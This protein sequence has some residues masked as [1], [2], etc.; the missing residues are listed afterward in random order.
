MQFFK[1]KTVLFDLDGT[2]ADN[3][4]AITKGVAYALGKLNIPA[5]TC[6][7]VKSVVGGSI[8]VTMERLIGKEL[9]T[10]AAKIYASKA[11]EYATFGL[12]AMPCARELLETLRAKKI[13][14]AC[15]TNKESQVAKKVLQYLKFDT[16]L[17]EII[18]TTLEGYRK[19][20]PEF[21][22]SALLKLGANPQD[23]II[24]GDSEFDYLSAQNCNIRSILVATGNDSVKKL[25]EL[26]PN[27]IAVC[28]NMCEIREK[29]FA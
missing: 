10:T 16:L 22:K 26:C 21:T 15:F 20:M 3:Y 8:Q 17:D 29:F 18:G 4:E 14:T 5:P 12:K 6:D 11:D 19:P 13:Q 2:L 24:I 7:K 25:K 28:K 27:A 23:T 1:P 9:A